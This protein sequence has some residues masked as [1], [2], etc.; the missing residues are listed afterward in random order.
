PNV[1]GMIEGSDPALKSEYV[2]YSAHSD[3]I[4]LAKTVKKDKINNGAMD[5]ASGTSIML[6]TARLFSELEE[7][8]KR[9]ILFVSVTGEEKGLLGADYYARHRQH[10]ARPVCD[11]RLQDAGRRRTIGHRRSRRDM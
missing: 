3:H 10:D 5:N 6:E 11:H 2:V 8:P 7:R 9:S 4:G 1:V